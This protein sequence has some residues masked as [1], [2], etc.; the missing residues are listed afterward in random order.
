MSE[1]MNQADPEKQQPQVVAMDVKDV[2]T[3]LE[4][5]EFLPAD[6]GV[7]S[8]DEQRLVALGLVARSHCHLHT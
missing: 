2:T 5:D 8:E 7:L 6:Y 3:V 1:S 4:E